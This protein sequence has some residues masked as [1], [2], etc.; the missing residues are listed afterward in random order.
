[1][2]PAQLSECSGA[3]L[4][5]RHAGRSSPPRT[6]EWFWFTAA[7]SDSPRQRCLGR[8]VVERHWWARARCRGFAYLFYGPDGENL[9]DRLRREAMA[10]SICREC[11]VATCCRTHA[12]DATERHGVWGGTSE[13]ERRRFKPR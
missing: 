5:R 11:P 8:S 10:K 2:W 13:A 4:C 9:G 3:S 12:F 7:E 1:M 6:D